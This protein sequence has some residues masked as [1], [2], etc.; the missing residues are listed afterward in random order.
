MPPRM[1]I[2]NVD[3]KSR[4]TVNCLLRNNSKK[5]IDSPH[6]I[7]PMGALQR[8]H[9][10]QDCS[11]LALSNE[12]NAYITDRVKLL[13]TETDGRAFLSQPTQYT[14]ALSDHRSRL[15]VYADDSQSVF[16]GF[17]STTASPALKSLG[18]VLLQPIPACVG[19]R[20]GF[21]LDKLSV[22]LRGHIGT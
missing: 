4:V 10:Q 22:Y 2:R 11:R 6:Q 3:L 7:T 15:T 9:R 19:C 21:V 12:E 16:G 5:Y 14:C 18:R 17:F 13:W 1:C 8:A 20:H